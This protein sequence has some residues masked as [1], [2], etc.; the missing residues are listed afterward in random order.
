LTYWDFGFIWFV[1]AGFIATLNTKD[2]QK[3]GL[4][5]RRANEVAKLVSVRHARQCLQRFG[6]Q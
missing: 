3:V 2:Y 4:C 1:V 6:I 5:V